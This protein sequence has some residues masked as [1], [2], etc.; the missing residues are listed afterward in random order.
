MTRLA[1]GAKFGNARGAAVASGTAQ[2]SV[3]CSRPESVA[4]SRQ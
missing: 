2:Q 1:R 4:G 3:Q